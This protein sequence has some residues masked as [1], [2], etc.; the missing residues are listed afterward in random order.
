MRASSSLIEPLV[1][2]LCQGD[3]VGLRNAALDVLE[4]LG[5]EAA[6]ALIAALPRSPENAR[7]FVVEALGEAGGPLVVVELKQAALSD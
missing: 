1:Q 2:A 4:E 5:E 7:K 3:N 6:P